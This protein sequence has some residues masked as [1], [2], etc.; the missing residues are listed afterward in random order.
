MVDGRIESERKCGSLSAIGGNY[1][2]QLQRQ[3]EKERN[4][5]TVSLPIEWQ[6]ICRSV[7]CSAVMC[8]Q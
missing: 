5:V 1:L 8:V 4:R 3:S 7:H 6:T 2:C